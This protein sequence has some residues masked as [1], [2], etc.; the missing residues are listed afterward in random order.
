MRCV[1]AGAKMVGFLGSLIIFE[2]SLSW[3]I[4]YKCHKSNKPSIVCKLTK[5]CKASL[6]LAIKVLLFALLTPTK[7]KKR[8]YIL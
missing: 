5:M 6:S 2:F 3:F 1:L 7:E 4:I 8:V